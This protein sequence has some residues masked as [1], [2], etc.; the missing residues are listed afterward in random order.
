MKLLLTMILFSCS[1]AHAVDAFRGPLSSALGGAGRA[2]LDGP[3]GV[4]L[5]PALVPLLKS[6]EIGTFFRDGYVDSGQHRQAWGFGAADNSPEVSFPGALHY[7]RLRDTGRAPKPVDG[8]LWHVAIGE[9]M[10]GERLAFGVSGQRL[11]YKMK[12]FRDSV[13]WNYS[14]GML[15]LISPELGFAYTLNNLAHPSSSVP[16]GLREEVQQAAG[17]YAVAGD[18][19]SVRLDISR[20]EVNNPAKKMVYMAAFESMSGKFVVFRSGYRRDEQQDA[21]FLTL[22]LG[23]NGPRLKFDYSFEK[24]LERTSGALHSVDLRL[25]F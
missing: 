1:L 6:V 25:P 9:M 11:T 14:L 4:L 15:V 22:G 17:L 16:V 13:Q 5:N 7:L 23:F 12:G 10:A 2:G 20:N 8:E 21:R 3:E 24:N 18:I 19:A